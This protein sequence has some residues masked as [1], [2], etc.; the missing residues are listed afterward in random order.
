[1][2]VQQGRL[3]PGNCYTILKKFW[4]P[5]TSDQVRNMKAFKNGLGVVFDIRS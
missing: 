3:G 2:S 1:M 5:R 4:D